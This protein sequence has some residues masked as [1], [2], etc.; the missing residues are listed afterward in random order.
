LLVPLCEVALLAFNH[1]AAQRWPRPSFSWR[2]PGSRKLAH[3]C[4]SGHDTRYMYKS[5]DM[6]MKIAFPAI[7]RCAIG[8]SSTQSD[9][10]AQ[11]HHLLR[12]RIRVADQTH[13]R[14]DGATN[15]AHAS[16]M[17]YALAHRESVTYRPSLWRFRGRCDIA[18]ADVPLHR[19]VGGY[20]CSLL[21]TKSRHESGILLL[22]ARS[23]CCSA[24]GIC[25]LEWKLATSS[26]FA[27]RLPAVM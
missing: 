6:H 23:D 7:T 2:W 11:P 25:G 13:R 26:L 20:L 22:Y 5:Y 16:S 8:V 19:W 10:L 17:I 9:C 1:F 21:G 14:E 12:W 24:A 4:W 3:G 15:L 18:V 27:R